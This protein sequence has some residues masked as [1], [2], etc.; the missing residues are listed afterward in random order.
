[1]SSYMDELSVLLKHMKESKLKSKFVC[2]DGQSEFKGNSEE[3]ASLVAKVDARFTF[4]ADDKKIFRN[5]RWIRHRLTRE[6][7]ANKEMLNHDKGLDML[8]YKYKVTSGCHLYTAKSSLAMLYRDI[9]S[10]LIEE[11]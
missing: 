10:M 1:M 8:D 5:K 6:N 2:L 7:S 4:I 11:D 3:L 9:I